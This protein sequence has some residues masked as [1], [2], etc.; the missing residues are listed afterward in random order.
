MDLLRNALQQGA[1]T[2]NLS[3]LIRTDRL[4]LITAA[5]VVLLLAS[6]KHTLHPVSYQKRFEGWTLV[7]FA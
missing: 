5:D 2:E 4:K 7:C 6:P 3:G 1:W